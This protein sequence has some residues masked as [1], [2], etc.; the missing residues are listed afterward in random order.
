VK[1]PYIHLSSR[2]VP[3]LPAEHVLLL[4]IETC[5]VTMLKQGQ[6]CAQCRFPR[7]AFRL[8]ILLLKA[9]YGADY[10]VLLACLCCP[11]KIFHKLVLASSYE[12]IETILASQIMGIRRRLEQV[13]L[14]GEGQIEKELKVVRRVVKER[15]GVNMLLQKHGFP[16]TVK[17]LHRK[18][19]LLMR[20]PTMAPLLLF[21]T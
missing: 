3:I 1:I 20:E 14:K 16:L 19:Y 18:G 21:H 17:N 12:Q 9:S 13:E 4:N 15:G 7:S 6:V 2:E 10:A 11:E 5:I 8:L